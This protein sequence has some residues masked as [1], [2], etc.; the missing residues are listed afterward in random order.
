MKLKYKFRVHHLM[1]SYPTSEDAIFDIINYLQDKNISLNKEWSDF[2]IKEAFHKKLSKEDISSLLQ[3]L[4]DEG[5]LL[6]REESKR[7][8]FKIIKNPF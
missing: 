5:F 7:N 4:I 3:K 1:D 8:Y 2:T 6:K